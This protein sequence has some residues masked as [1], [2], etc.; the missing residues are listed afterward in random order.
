MKVVNPVNEGKRE[1]YS[2]FP[3]YLGGVGGAGIALHGSTC[4][5]NTLPSHTIR[6]SCHHE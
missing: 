2:A 5:F 6:L 1:S 3:F 4:S